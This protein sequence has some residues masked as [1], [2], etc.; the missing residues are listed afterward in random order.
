MFSLVLFV[1]FLML[2]F[3]FSLVVFILCF[4]FPSSFTV[5]ALDIIKK[6]RLTQHSSEQNFE[7]QNEKLENLSKT[8]WVTNSEHH[9]E[10]YLCSRKALVIVLASLQPLPDRRWLSNVSKQWISFLGMPRGSSSNSGT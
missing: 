7:K 2:L 9:F 3:F 6:K 5:V 4:C 8:R 1:L 10:T